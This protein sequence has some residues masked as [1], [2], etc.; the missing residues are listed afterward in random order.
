MLVYAQE[1]IL[2]TKAN[3]I[4]DLKV[5]SQMENNIKLNNK[6]N[7]FQVL[8]CVEDYFRNIAKG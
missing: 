3:T 5:A 6:N 8:C 1:R 7:S 4:T 2:Y